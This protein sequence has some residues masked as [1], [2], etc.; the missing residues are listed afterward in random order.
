MARRANR[1]R[2]TPTQRPDRAVRSC[3]GSA[4]TGA[5][6]TY[7]IDGTTYTNTTGIFTS[8][9][10]G[11]YFVTA[12]N[13]AGCISASTSLTINKQ[14]VTPPA[15]TVIATQPT[16][17]I[18]TGTITVTE[19]IEA[20]MTYSIDGLTYT[21]TTGVFI[22]LDPGTYSVSA[23]STMG[24][25]SASTS[26][27]I[28]AIP[29]VFVPNVFTPNADGIHDLFAINCLDPTNYPNAQMQ[30][31]NR[32]GNLVYKNDHYG[33]PDLWNGRS[34]NKLNVINDELPV[35]TYYYVLKL[36]DGKVLSGY[37]FLAK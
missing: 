5:G 12:K 25:I 9:A 7:S 31:F 28:N 23:K 13:A 11:N 15:P 22:P 34:V 17:D 1:S 32:N 21:N 20:G 4:P 37:I 36:G 19:P 14:P 29:D 30:I 27:T 8:V 18:S 33:N 3:Q 35:G 6:T 2:W 16:C 26:I 24:C 10:G